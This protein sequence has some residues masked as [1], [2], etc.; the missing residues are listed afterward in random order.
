MLHVVTFAV[1]SE[2]L[3]VYWQFSICK[4]CFMKSHQTGSTADLPVFGNSIPNSDFPG[5]A[6]GDQLVTNEEKS[7]HWNIQAEDACMWT[8]QTQRSRSWTH[9]AFR[10]NTSAHIEN[11]TNF[12]SIAVGTN[13]PQDDL[14]HWGNGHHLVIVSQW[15]G[16]HL[17]IERNSVDHPVQT[18]RSEDLLPPGGLLH[19]DTQRIMIQY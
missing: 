3:H 7:L 9:S 10:W 5:V 12:I 4:M 17:G 13:G 1:F 14:S 8:T 16:H 6:G 11:R 2:M 18:R 19:P 15:A